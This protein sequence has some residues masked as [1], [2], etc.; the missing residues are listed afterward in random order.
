MTGVDTDTDI[1]SANA[2][3]LGLDW[4]TAT[5]SAV[6]SSPV[7]AYDTKLGSTLVYIG[8]S[9]G[10][11]EAVNS[12]DG[13][14]FWSDNLGAPILATP[15]VYNGN[16]WV[17]TFAAPFMYKIND[18]TGSVLC[19]ISLGTGSDMS[20]PTIATPPGGNTSVYLGV[21]D[22]G[23]VSSPFEAINEQTCQVEWT[24]FPYSV[25][26]GSWN[27]SSFAVNA[28]GVPMMLGGSANPD[29]TVYA[30]NAITGS[31]IWKS[32]TEGAELSDVGAGITVSPPGYNGFADGVAY[33]P[34]E[35]GKLFALNL[36]T[37]YGMWTFDYK[38]ATTPAHAIGGRSA[39]DLVGNKFIFGTDTGVMAVNAI[40]GT[41]IWDSAKTVAPDTDIVSS[42]L[43]AG[44]P[45]E[46][47]V[48]YGDMDGNFLVLNESNGHLLYSFPTN[49]F[50][51][52]SPAISGNRLFIASSNG[53]L[54][55][56]K[57]GG[58]TSIAYPT[59]LVGAPMNHATV[60][61]PN[62][63]SS[64]SAN[65]PV[66]GTAVV[67]GTG[68]HVLVAI[69]S[70]GPTGDWW[71]GAHSAWQAG[72]VWNTVALSATGTWDYS[73]PVGTAGAV[74]TAF[75][76]AEASSGAVDPNGSQTT[77]TISPTL[78]SPRI[79]LSSTFA[80]P[81][82]QLLVSGSGFSSKETVQIGIPGT[83]LASPVS[84]AAGTFS[85]VKI[86]IPSHLSFGV[87]GILAVGQNS[88]R[89]TSA[90]LSVSEPWTQLGED[91]ARLGH[92][93]FD[94]YLSDQEVPDKIYRY[95]ANVVVNLGAPIASSAAVAN[96][97]VYVGTTA[98]VIDAVDGDTGAIHWSYLTGAAVNS[99]P[100]I[101]LAAN[102]LI[103]GS[104]DG[105]VYALNLTTGAL[106][107]SRSTGGAV[108]SSPTIVNGIVYIG[109]D[110]GKLFALNES[111]GAIAW[112]QSLGGPISG[113]P[114]VDQN[115]GLV[116]VGDNSG[117][118]SAFATGG[119][120]PGHPM[121]S[122]K[123]T[124]G[125]NTPVV[126]ST[127]AYVGS[128][129]GTVYAVNLSTG[130]IVWTTSLHGAASS[131]MTALGANLLVGSGNGSLF[132][133]DL[134]TGKIGWTNQTGSPV[135]GVSSTIDLIYTESAG[136]Q[137]SAFRTNEKDWIGQ[138]GT[139]L[140]GTISVSDNG[141]I[142]GGG[143]GDLYV[144]TPY[145]LPLA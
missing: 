50:I 128:S 110:S 35:D 126:L 67:V 102:L 23:V 54:Y 85:H 40:N 29:S 112:S 106:V 72:I 109:S 122:D 141:V 43:V 37:G 10:Y 56:F 108:S 91:P 57:I 98:G 16:L 47:I 8:T 104:N 123:L 84:T 124:G 65:V 34:G 94:Y 61:N 79:S 135:T 75:A 3:T 55:S 45:G 119:T 19:Q 52:P 27:P 44:P 121:W 127:F 6:D 4:M 70:D 90:A 5:G 36:T 145:G 42:P 99:S 53:F 111:T 88:N 81:G 9:G 33:Y 11:L 17:G 20:S 130:A 22:N 95:V 66:N 59:T 26:S 134:R 100:A 113:S 136:G 18:T 58:S 21:Q 105:H 116:V 78:S 73:A 69:Q 86:V 129:K 31:L 133:L 92:L 38:R 114:A 32:Q 46:Q 68:G 139:S 97:F 101:D 142:V 120:T 143:N 140:S 7:V 77:F 51:L 48:A 28:N 41:E 12:V 132:A 62:L 49:G 117:N 30:M 14:I 74:W 64:T 93:P 103:V 1:T 118:L 76:R 138:A 144:F 115:R 82:D 2:N 107:W 131:T 39:G 96:G 89:S 83:T 15:S 60:A 24:A 137:L 125:L 63:G 25:E 87:V 13:R 80:V 71:N